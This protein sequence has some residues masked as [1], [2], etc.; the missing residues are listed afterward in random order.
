MKWFRTKPEDKL[1]NE[2]WQESAN[3]GKEILG[4]LIVVIGLPITCAVFYLK[5]KDKFFYD[6]FLMLLILNPIIII[7]WQIRSVFREVCRRM[8]KQEET[9][10]KFKKLLG[11]TDPSNQITV[12]DKEKLIDSLITMLDNADKETRRFTAQILGELGNPRAL[13]A[14]SNL[15]GD[16]DK[17]VASAAMRSIEKLTI[18]T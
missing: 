4:L 18:K 2:I 6:Y 3:Q 13:S 14:L 17:S 15:L 5:T 11:I 8:Q 1:W 10:D 7:L 9:M 16:S 12:Q